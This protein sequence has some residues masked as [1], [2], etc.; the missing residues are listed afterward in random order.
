[1]VGAIAIHADLMAHGL[2]EPALDARMLETPGRWC[3]S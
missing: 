1:M 3:R 2:G